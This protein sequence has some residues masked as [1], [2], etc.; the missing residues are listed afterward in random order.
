[1]LEPASRVPYQHPGLIHGSGRGEVNHRAAK[2]LWSPRTLRGHSVH[3]PGSHHP[4]HT[5]RQHHILF[6]PPWA[7]RDSQL[8]PHGHSLPPS[9]AVGKFL[10]PSLSIHPTATA[11]LVSAILFSVTREKPLLGDHSCASGSPLQHSF[12]IS[13]F[14]PKGNPHPSYCSLWHHSPLSHP[15]TPRQRCTPNPI[16]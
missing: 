11:D 5:D 9:L 10:R 12:L 1:M 6:T 4:A 3:P 8:L 15:R 2:A 16:R 7:R 13:W 14:F